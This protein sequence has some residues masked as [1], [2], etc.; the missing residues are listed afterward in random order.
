MRRA[1]LVAVFCLFGGLAGAA[2]PRPPSRVDR[3]E[4]WLHAI[5]N[6]EPGSGDDAAGAIASWPAATVRTL[7]VD[8]NNLLALTRDAYI[9]RFDLRQPGQRTSPQIRY[10]PTELRRDL[11]SFTGGRLFEIEK[12]ANLS[13]IFLSV[14]EEFRQRYLVSYTPRGVAKDGWHRLTVTV[15]R[16]ATVKARPG[17]LAGS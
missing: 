16:G 8:V 15:K 11:T 7:W 5:A 12:T 2:G 17:Y 9:G 14:L 13:A 10:T 1:R 6:H 3:V 4:Q